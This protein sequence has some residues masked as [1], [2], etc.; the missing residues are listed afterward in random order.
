MLFIRVAMAEW[1]ARRTP[2][3]KIVGSS[4]AKASQPPNKTEKLKVSWN[5]IEAQFNFNFQAVES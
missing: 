3:Q 4:P 1:L 5:W 2:N